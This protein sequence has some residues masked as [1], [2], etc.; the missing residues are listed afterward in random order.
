M[1]AG[2]QTIPEVLFRQIEK[3]LP[4]AVTAIIVVNQRKEILLIKRAIEPLMGYW[5]LPGGRIERGER[6]KDTAIRELREETGIVA[7]SIKELGVTTLNIPERSAIE[8][9]FLVDVN[10]PKVSLNN[11]ASEYGWFQ[12]TNLPNK[13]VP[14]LIEAIKL[15]NNTQKMEWSNKSKYN[16]FNS[17]K[18]LTYI[19]H[20]S[21]IVNWFNGK[22]VLPPP[23]ECSLD[24]IAQCN[25]RCY[26]CNSQ[27]YLR[28]N[29]KETEMK[30]L[31]R[32]HMTRLIRFLAQWGVR[33]LCWGGGGESLL[34]K[35]M[36]GLTKFA[37]EKGM[38]VSV[39]TNGIPVD[40]ELAEE[41]TLCRWV[42]ISIETCDR[43]I[44][45]KTK[46]ADALPRVI[47][48]T[49]LLVKKKL[50]SRSKVDISW[51]VLVLPEIINT[52]YDTCKLAKSLG[53][54]DFHVRPVDLERKDFKIARRL[55]LDM[56]KIKEIFAK[57][58]E[59]ETA[60]FR[61]FTVMHKYD[62]Q[63]H[64]K[65]DFSRCIAAP[66]VIQCCTSGEVSNCVDHRLEPRFRLGWHYPEPEDILKWWGNEHHKQLLL[67]IIPSK[68]CGRCTWS[69]FNRQIEEVVMK[70]SMCLAFP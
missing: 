55:N 49:K 14:T 68:E 7:T 2:T 52:I 21:G 33:G 48:N 29:P 27:R 38:E 41:L 70:D 51:K 66:I 64:M 10:S 12:L 39:V 50:E 46:G 26:W 43:E 1:E 22:G 40:E 11:E 19:T 3:L 44:Y 54:R 35:D 5:N 4:L 47:E 9:N 42:G 59:E 20:Y 31:P 37:V 69:E 53:V 56:P 17:M 34:A 16:S 24:P 15:I 13:I 30:F 58:H 36:R 65:H 61:V 60:D 32:E 63:F 8:I 62:E 57:C 28:E 23:I 45:K 18:G 25:L 6:P 67:S